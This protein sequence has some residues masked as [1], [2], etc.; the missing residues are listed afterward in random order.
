MTDQAPNIKRARAVYAAT[1]HLKL[2]E[3]Q[4]LDLLDRLSL[5][6]VA[7]GLRQIGV[8][9]GEGLQLG[10]V[11]DATGNCGLLTSVAESVWFRSKPAA[12]A[13]SDGLLESLQSLRSSESAGSNVLWLYASA[14]DRKR[15]KGKRLAK[16]EA[17]LLLG[18][19]ECCVRENIE[20]DGQMDL[21]YLEALVAKVG[22]D[23]EAIQR[24]I[25]DDLEVELRGAP[26]GMENVS[27]TAAKFPFVVH[28]SCK[29]CL[30]SLDSPSAT[31]NTRYRALIEEVDPAMVRAMLQI[32]A[33]VSELD[34]TEDREKVFREIGTIHHELLRGRD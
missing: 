24:A 22:R 16:E 7:A 33:L 21:L 34:H 8:L 14:E 17:G 13:G 18:Y 31:L 6:T 5:L 28:I 32:N 23:R 25:L 3:I 2:S 30:S 20:S 4:P 9:E 29:A 27:A 15:V 10:E 12:Q 19:P 26:P 11:K 1:N